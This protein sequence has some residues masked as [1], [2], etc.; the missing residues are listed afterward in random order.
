MSKINFNI[1]QEYSNPAFQAFSEFQTECTKNNK[2][3]KS[4]VAITHDYDMETYSE[5]G[6]SCTVVVSVGK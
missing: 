2:M 6:M 3:P 1:M 4:E 5:D